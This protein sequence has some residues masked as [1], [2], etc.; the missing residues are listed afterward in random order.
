[1]DERKRTSPERRCKATNRRGERCAAHVVNAAGYCVAH[2]P[3]R[4]DSMRE[5]G[6][7]SGEARR[8]G[9]AAQ[10]PE[11]EREGLRAV[12]R[13]R[14]D[15]ETVIAAIERALAGGNE[16][17]RVS[18]VKF[19]ADLELYRQDDKEE[20]DQAGVM[21]AAGERFERLIRDRAR[22]VR[23]NGSG[24]VD[25]RELTQ[26]ARELW[27]PEGVT[28][29]GVIVRDVSASDAVATLEGLVDR[30]LIRPPLSAR[31]KDERAAEIERLK[32]EV[33]RLKIQLSEFTGVAV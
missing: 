30:G 9:P 28:S 33:K 31:E 19:L 11:P 27:A 6:R 18:A 13:D 23:R 5:L 21:A 26:A 20:R 14:L 2:D 3:E 24:F 16:S 15:H 7:R 10:L 8:R 29:E 32:A 4:P 1:M 22:A 17:A 12:L 25:V